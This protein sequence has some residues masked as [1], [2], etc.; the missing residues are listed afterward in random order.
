MIEVQKTDRFEKWIRR[1]KDRQARTII[2]SHIDRLQDGLTGDIKPV[3]SG[4]SELRIHHGP[5][6]RVYLKRQ[7]NVLIVVLCAGN[8]KTQQKDI[9][10]A[11][12]IAGE[13]E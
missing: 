7:G 3:G 6:Y 9:A 5:G 4:V 1:L 10:L 12:S 13:L 2:L 11:I 8:K